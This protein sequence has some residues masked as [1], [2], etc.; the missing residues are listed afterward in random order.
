MKKYLYVLSLLMLLMFACETDDNCNKLDGTIISQDFTLSQIDEI[1]VSVPGDMFIKQATDYALEIRTHEDFF[2]QLNISESNK[3]LNITTDG[4][5]ENLDRFEI[6]LSVPDLKR[7]E[8]IGAGNVSTVNDIDWDELSI[9]LIGAGDFTFS[10]AVDD[11]Y[12][13][14]QGAGNFKGFDLNTR[15]AEIRIQGSGNVEISCTE[16]LNV[17]ISGV[18]NVYYKGNPDTQINISGVG[19]VVR[20]D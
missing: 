9:H 5:I 19:E 11:F 12:F 15:L 10:G 7:I 16:F 8:W 1:S 18:G 20:L 14:V 17:T 4:C 13:I 6:H 3:K 2:D